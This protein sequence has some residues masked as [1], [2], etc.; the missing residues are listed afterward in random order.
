M[1][2]VPYIDPWVPLG[3]ILRTLI[4][5]SLSDSVKWLSSLFFYVR[6]FSILWNQSW[7]KGKEGLLKHRFLVSKPRVS[8]SADLGWGL[9]ICLSDNF[10]SDWFCWSGESHFENHCSSEC[11]NLCFCHCDFMIFYTFMTTWN[12]IFFNLMWVKQHLC[13][14]NLYYSDY[15]YWEFYFIWSLVIHS[16]PAVNCH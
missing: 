5:S 9:R 12:V 11:I 13:D 8:D 6:N 1:L 7:D 2:H 3:F 16:E 14:F 4:P 15:Y 10:P